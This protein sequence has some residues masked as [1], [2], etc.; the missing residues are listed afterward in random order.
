MLTFSG[1]GE[2]IWDRLTHA[3]PDNIKGGANGDIA[4]DS[5]HKYKE[6]VQLLKGLNVSCN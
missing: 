3:H 5:Y 1:K 2:N 6:D 4:D